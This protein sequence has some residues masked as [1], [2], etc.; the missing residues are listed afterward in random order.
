MPCPQYLNLN[1]KAPQR[2]AALGPDWHKARQWKL[3][4][5]EAAHA[6][7]DQGAPGEW[8][9]H[10]GSYFRDERFSDEILKHMNHTGWYCDADCQETARGLVGRLSHGRFIAG[11]FLS[12]NGERVYFDEVFDDEDDA[13]RMADEHARV[14][15]EREQEFDQRWQAARDIE[16]KIEDAIKR[17]TECLLLARINHSRDAMREEAQDLKEKIENWREELKTDYKDVE[18]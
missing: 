14:I 7:L 12:M 9:H 3:N 16:S 15:G 8:Y 17:R 18:L 4:S 5:W 10:D 1:L 2:L 11:Y 6:V 13:A